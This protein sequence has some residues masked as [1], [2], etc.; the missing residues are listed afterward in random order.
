[1]PRGAG[2]PAEGG[3]VT[4]RGRGRDWQSRGAAPIATGR[5]A[6]GWEDK[7]KRGAAGRMRR[8]LGFPSLYTSYQQLG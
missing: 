2:A 1:M 4:G 8:E 7:G 3:G 6:S 5:R